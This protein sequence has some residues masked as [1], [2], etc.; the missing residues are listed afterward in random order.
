M[1]NPIPD[2]SAFTL[3]EAGF[4]I[5][6]GKEAEFFERQSATVP[7]AMS[8]PGFVAV[9]GGPILDSS[10]LYFGVRFSSAA[11]MDAWHFHQHHQ[12]V[13]KMAYEK[14]WTAVYIRKWRRLDA[15]LP[16]G[17]RLMCE[18]RLRTSAPLDAAQL[19]VVRSSLATLGAAG[20]RRF[21]TQSGEFEPQPWQFVGPVEI[22]PSDGS[23]MYSLITHWTSLEAAEAWHRSAGC[24][25]LRT[26]GAL[27]H[28]VFT[29][30]EERGKRHGLRDDRL[31]RQWK[32]QSATP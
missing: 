10:W 15:A 7:V 1:S 4:K 30:L 27:E 9:Y 31:Q 29:A 21:E 2:D 14:W 3:M 12:E 26:L 28:E 17:D 16:A 18:T 8:Q 32:L 5:I 23:V 19:D 20:A 22:A 24:D 13:Q 11:H 25:V 6:P